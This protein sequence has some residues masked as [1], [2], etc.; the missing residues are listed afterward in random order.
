M[1]AGVGAVACAVCCAA[2]ILGVLAAIGL[3]TVPATT[4]LGVAGLLI[5][6]VVGAMVA[7]RRRVRSESC[8]TTDVPVTIGS[9]PARDRQHG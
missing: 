7:T 8:R 1:V 9:T 6:A 2:P 5:G 3:G 4:L